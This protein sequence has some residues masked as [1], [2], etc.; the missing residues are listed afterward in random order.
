MQGAK[1]IITGM[2]RFAEPMA[3]REKTLFDAVLDAPRVVPF[4]DLQTIWSRLGAVVRAERSKPDADLQS[5]ARLNQLRT[6]VSNNISGAAEQ[7]AQQ[8]AQA[9]AAGTMAPED[10]L[11]ARLA[12]KEASWDNEAGAQNVRTVLDTAK[13]G[14][15]PSVGRVDLPE[16]QG[17]S[18]GVSVVP[19]AGGPQ[20]RGLGNAPGGPSVPGEAPPA[21]ALVPNFD[22]DAAARYR[23][24]NAS[25]AQ[26]VQ[27]F[28]TGPVGAVL[29]PGPNGTPFKVADSAVAGKF[30]NSTDHAGEDVQALL[31]AVGS[32]PEAVAALQDFAASDLLKTAGRPDGTL[33]PI[34]ADKWVAQHQ[35]ALAPFP[36]LAGKIGTATDA[37]RA[38]AGVADN[39]STNTAAA[40]QLVDDAMAARA[41]ATKQAQRFTAAKFIG[42]DPVQVI[43]N[44]I[45]SPQ[46]AQK[47]ARWAA[48]D[49]TGDATTGLQRATIENLQ[50]RFLTGSPNAEEFRR[51]PFQ[52]FLRQN[53]DGL[54][55]ILGDD[56]VGLLDKLSQDLDRTNPNAGGS[57]A[58]P[59]PQNSAGGSGHG[60]SIPSM[61]AGLLTEHL[62]NNLFASAAAAGA[63][64]MVGAFRA[65]GLSTV[66][67]IV[68]EALLN[69][70]IG[71]TLLRRYSPKEQALAA[72]T[73]AKRIMALDLT[74]EPKDSD[75][76]PARSLGA[77]ASSPKPDVVVANSRYTGLSPGTARVK[78]WEDALR[79]LRGSYT[80]IDTGW[81]I[82]LS[83]AGISK[84]LSGDGSKVRAEIVANLPDLI[85]NATLDQSGP[86]YR[87][88]PG[89]QAMHRMVVP[90]QLDGRLN[91]VQL[92]I[93]EYTD[94]RK[95]H[96]AVDHFE[97]GQ[98][99]GPSR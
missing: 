93:R 87:A 65:K 67:Q 63:T 5:I 25:Y 26:G 90:F 1:D 3:G 85:R 23:A 35:D 62:T 15:G 91:N 8:Q 45:G 89:T 58:A 7:V 17:G 38:V 77:A 68:T 24:A 88:Q 20:G 95:A 30:F 6:A 41:Q 84:S 44:V 75:G 83:R 98:G 53:R 39:V 97:V 50:K 82:D 55:T 40:Q 13:T 14:T 22:S 73:L 72:P 99:E 81:D 69:P 2:S 64:K 19:G 34:K 31:N 16:A 9:V 57:G 78:A 42:A 61:L 52:N 27:T 59:A 86:D 28:G 32:R 10:T 74:R 92:T 94:G 11:A 36:E 70:Q 96:Y 76:P 48:L 43:G 37:Q 79:D 33:D 46:D 12:G 80:N 29:R 4:S 66:D 56:R 51:A 49:P 71:Q 60:G 18:G 47:M 54:T 21:Q